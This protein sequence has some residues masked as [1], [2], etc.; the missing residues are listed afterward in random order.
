MSPVIVVATAFPAP[1]HRAEVIAAF[2]A[3]IAQ[4]HAEEPGCELYALHEGPDGRLVMI[5][6]YA[7]QDAVAAHGKGDGLAGLRKALGGKLSGPLDVQYLA[8]HPAGTPGKGAL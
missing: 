7:S 1:E 5:E 2:E 4:V 3:A 8:P 6:K